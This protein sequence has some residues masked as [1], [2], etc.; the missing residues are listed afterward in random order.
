MKERKKKNALEQYAI[1]VD[2][3]HTTIICIHIVHNCIVWNMVEVHL[4][5]DLCRP[6]L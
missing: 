2:K 6:K 3:H 4:S 5:L 1:E